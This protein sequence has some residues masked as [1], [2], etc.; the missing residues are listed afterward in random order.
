[1]PP[2][3]VVVHYQRIGTRAGV[4]AL[5]RISESENP[6]DI[7]DMTSLLASTSYGTAWHLYAEQMA[8]QDDPSRIRMYRQVWLPE[9]QN[10]ETGRVLERDAQMDN[11]LTG[12]AYAADLA[13]AIESNH[14]DCFDNTKNNYELGKVLAHMGA[15]LS[16][17]S[18]RVSGEHGTPE[19]VQGRVLMAAERG[20]TSM[21]QLSGKIDSRPSFAQVADEHSPLRRQLND[22]PTLLSQ[23]AHKILLEEI[24]EASAA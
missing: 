5:D 1:M 21:L 19:Q 15:R 6:H 17:V 23:K 18:D 16:V 7:D 11:V 4:E 12:L 9:L 22:D 14:V 3:F 24:E 10:P 13:E 8:F 2:G 20:R